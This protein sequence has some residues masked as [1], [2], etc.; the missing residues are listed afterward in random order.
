MFIITI[1]LYNTTIIIDFRIDQLGEAEIFVNQFDDEI[2]DIIEDK[3]TVDSLLVLHGGGIERL[4][5]TGDKQTI[6]TS[7]KSRFSVYPDISHTI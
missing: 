2:Y 4:S 3:S 6:L 1:L 5:V 7:S